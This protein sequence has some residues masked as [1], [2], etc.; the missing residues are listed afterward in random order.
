MK[1]F[2]AS[3]FYRDKGDKRAN[4]MRKKRVVWGLGLVFFWESGGIGVP[5]GLM[6]VPGPE[7]KRERELRRT[8]GERTLS[9]EFL[10]FKI[11]CTSDAV[12]PGQRSFPGESDRQAPSLH[13][14]Q[15]TGTCPSPP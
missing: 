1:P 14:P 11:S 10:I 6:W 3:G 5:H 4:K 9:G 12:T 7:S 13:H 8:Q 2:V 15:F